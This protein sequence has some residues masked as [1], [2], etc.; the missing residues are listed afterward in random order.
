MRRVQIVN[1]LKQRMNEILGTDFG[2]PTTNDWDPLVP[3]VSTDPVYALTPWSIQAAMISNLERLCAALVDN[4]ALGKV[5]TGMV[6]TPST[7]PNVTILPGKAVTPSGKLITL[8]GSI[9]DV[10]MGATNGNVRYIYLYYVLAAIDGDNDSR[11]RNTPFLGGPTKKRNIVYDELGSIIGSEVTNEPYR[12]AILS[13][14]TSFANG[15]DK[16]LIAIVTTGTGTLSVNMNAGLIST[17][18]TVSCKNLSASGTT[19]LQ[20]LTSPT[21]TI[22]ALDAPTVAATTVTA[23]GLVTGSGFKVGAAPG[24][25]GT[26]IS[27]DGS[28]KTIQVVNGIITSIAP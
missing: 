18:G 26:F 25:T 12:S 22:T 4:Q 5:L 13:V 20:G 3:T 10:A 21:A 19:A 16:V 1:N 17:G 15:P 7:F 8:S 24:V 11:G 23:S 2:S 6:V 9:V 14:E 28:P 27:A